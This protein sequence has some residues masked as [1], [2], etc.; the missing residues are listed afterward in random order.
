MKKMSIHSRQRRIGW[1]RDTG[2]K[3]Y[4]RYGHN[5]KVKYEGTIPIY[6]PHSTASVEQFIVSPLNRFIELFLPERLTYLPKRRHLYSPKGFKES[7]YPDIDRLG[8]EEFLWKQ[9]PFGFHLRSQQLTKPKTQSDVD[10]LRGIL[11]RF[12][13]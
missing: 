13:P 12:A 3:I 7:G 9:K 11:K 8:W 5:P 4:Q 10:F 6:K 1:S 2:F